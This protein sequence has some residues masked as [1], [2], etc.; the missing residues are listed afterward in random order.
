MTNVS[1]TCKSG[2]VSQV[3]SYEHAKIFIATL[4]QLDILS[5]LPFPLFYSFLRS[6]NLVPLIYGA[7]F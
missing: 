3:I 2:R 1:L 6:P 4:N 5:L 7:F